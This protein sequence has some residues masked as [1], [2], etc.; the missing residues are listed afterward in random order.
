MRARVTAH[1]HHEQLGR[2]AVREGAGRQRHER[3]HHPILTRF[4]IARSVG[5]ETGDDA[6]C[7]AERSPLIRT[8]DERR[9]RHRIGRGCP[10]CA[11]A[12]NESHESCPRRRLF[13]ATRRDEHRRSPDCRRREYSAQA[14]GT[15]SQ[16]RTICVGS[17]IGSEEQVQRRI[18]CMHERWKPRENWCVLIRE[19]FSSKGRVGRFRP[20]AG[21]DC[22]RPTCTV[23]V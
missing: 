17:S 15:R 21:H 12:A 1:L 22:D 16:V 11:F 19:D 20:W 4:A 6:H 23:R 14:S 2:E 7:G 18:F 13:R 8:H 3:W 9:T 10:L 5:E